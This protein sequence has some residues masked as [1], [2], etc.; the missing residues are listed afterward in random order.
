MDRRARDRPGRRGQPDRRAAPTTAGTPVRGTTRRVPMTDLTKFPS[1]RPAKWSS[2]YPTVATS[3]LTFLTGLGL[4]PLA[5]RH[6]RS[7]CSRARASRL[8]FLDPETKVVSGPTSLGEV[9]QYGRIRTVQYG[10]GRGALLHHLQRQRQRR[11]SAGS[12]PRPRRRRVARGT[13]ISPVGVVGRPHRPAT[14]TSSSA[15]PATGSTTSAAPTTAA[16]GPRAG[17]DTGLTSTSAPS[18]ASSATGR[19]RPA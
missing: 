3:G 10:T 2:G 19:V 17:R 9:S 15:R 8:L 14:C 4:G 11:A 6:G 16:R 12:A 18:C 1:G 13:D 5:G 7:R